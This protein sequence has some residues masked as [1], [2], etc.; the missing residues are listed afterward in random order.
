MSDEKQPG[1]EQSA[2]EAAELSEPKSEV[3]YSQG[4]DNGY[5]NDPY[6]YDEYGDSGGG[7]RYGES[8]QPP[9]QLAAAASVASPVAAAPTAVVATT[10]PAKP[11]ATAS[12]AGGAYN[13]PPPPKPPDDEEDEEED[14]M[15]RMSFLEHLEELRTRIIRV[16]MGF[17]GAFVFSL[18]FAPEIWKIIAAPAVQALTN[19]GFTPKLVA[20]APMEQ[21]SIIWMKAPMIVSIFLASPVLVWQVWGFIAPGLYKRERRWAAPFILC[22]S[23][24]FIL[25]GLFAYFVVFRFGLEFLLGIGRD[26]DVAPMVTISEYFDLFV[27]VT[28]GVAIIFELPIV[29]FFLT[30]IRV[31]SPKF[32]LGHSRYAILGIMILAA[33]VTPTPDIFN[34]MMFTVP[35]ILLY[36]IGLFASYL[37]ELNR[38]GK[39]FPWKYV[40]FAVIGVL[41]VCGGLLWLAVAKFGVKLLPYWPFLTK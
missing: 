18:I 14:G 19:L 33:I 5:Q 37:L 2:P 21:F 30:L 24:L 29:I 32:L 3:H 35:M 13:P 4:V 36:F 41:A 1:A 9:E 15:A 7:Y 34:M 11:P 27:N 17:G 26:A 28:L 38:D 10:A 16:L 39:K 31:A 22:T 40:V 20:I 23:G 12:Q 25:G 8:T 6:A